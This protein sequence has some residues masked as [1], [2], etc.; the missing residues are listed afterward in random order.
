M[1]YFN[2]LQFELFIVKP[3][4]RFILAILKWAAGFVNIIVESC[5]DWKSRHIIFMLQLLKSPIILQIF[6]FGLILISNLCVQVIFQFDALIERLKLW[7]ITISFGFQTQ[8]KKLLLKNLPFYFSIF[9]FIFLSHL[10]FLGYFE[11]FESHILHGFRHYYIWVP[12][13]WLPPMCIRHLRAHQF[14]SRWIWIRL[15]V[16]IIIR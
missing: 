5:W 14:R 6:L 2:S 16:V 1:R 3:I 11:I 4:L 7:Q 8:I 10:L 12:I 15:F 13:F 9:L